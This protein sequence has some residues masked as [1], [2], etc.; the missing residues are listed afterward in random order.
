MR[1]IHLVLISFCLLLKVIWASDSEDFDPLDHM[2]KTYQPV[3]D[4]PEESKQTITPAVDRHLDERCRCTCPGFEVPYVQ[5]KMASK[6]YI[7]N[8][9]NARDCSCPK[10]VLPSIPMLEPKDYDQANHHVCP[11]CKCVYQRRNLTV[12]FGVVTFVIILIS[13][14]VVYLL[15]S[16]VV[17]PRVILLTTYKEH[18]DDEVNIS[19]DFFL[20]LPRID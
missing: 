16:Q 7:G 19:I 2:I 18:K 8:V 10:I 4:V 15:V 3:K 17:W 13:T 14:F 20:N 6:I 5:I 1:D 12:M 11:M 9:A